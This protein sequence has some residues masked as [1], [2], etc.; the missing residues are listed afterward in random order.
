[1]SR[2]LG[3]GARSLSAPPAQLFSHY[4]T[5]VESSSRAIPSVF[6]PPS[7]L[8]CALSLVSCM[9]VSLTFSHG[10]ITCPGFCHYAPR[11]TTPR[12]PF[13]GFWPYNPLPRSSA[14]QVEWF[15]LLTDLA[16][17]LAADVICR[18]S[19]FCRSGAV[20]VFS[21]DPHPEKTA[22]LSMRPF[23]TSKSCYC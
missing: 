10:F 23:F 19:F 11:I 20:R 1:M 16:F 22:S 21:S 18:V 8:W 3:E 9:T 4:C 13:R 2:R 7:F 15:G 5:P 12:Y 17:S 6:H 14:L